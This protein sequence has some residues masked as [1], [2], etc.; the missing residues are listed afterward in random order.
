[1]IKLGVSACFLYPDISREVYGHKQLD[2]I[3]NDMARFLVDLG[4]VPILIPD[5]DE[6]HQEQYFN[7]MD[8]FVLQGGV[9]LAP[10]SYG[11]EP[12]ENGRWPGDRKRDLYEFKILDYARKSKKPVLGICRGFQVLN[13]YFG[14]TL[15]QDLGIQTGTPIEHRCAQKYDRVHHSIDIKKDS[16]MHEV[17]GSDNILVNSIHHQGVKDL[18]KDLVVESICPDDNLIEA[19]RYKNMD[20]QFIWGMQWHPEFN[21]TLKDKVAS[22]EPIFNRFITEIKKNKKGA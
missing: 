9:D 4:V 18:G 3:E 17:Y 21:H 14:G 6:E 20:E 7:E 2:Y 5:L 11:E 10:E 22:S 19:F 8:A 12:I 16:L 13:V 15:Y 1:M